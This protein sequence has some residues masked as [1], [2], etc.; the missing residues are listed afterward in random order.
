M[1][2]YVLWLTSFVGLYMAIFWIQI[3]YFAKDEDDAIYDAK[4]VTIIIPAFN[5]ESSI[6]RALKSLADLD[7]PKDKLH[8]I[9]VDDGSTDDTAGK[10]SK[11][12]SENPGIRINLVRH[13][14]NSGNKAVALNTGLQHVTT[15]FFGC[16]DA[17]S[18]AA[19]SSLRLLMQKFTNEN[20][21]AVIST[22]KIRSPVNLIERVQRLD[23]II[24]AFIRK[25]MSRINTLHVTP[26]VLSIYR[27][28]VIRQLG[29][30][31][32]NN[33]TEDLEIAMR[34]QYHRYIIQMQPE[35][36]T[37]TEVP[38]TLK[39]LWSQ[40]VRWYRG[41]IFNSL[42]YREMLF[43][44]KHG[45]MGTFQF[46]MNVLAV[47]IVFAMF[48]IS[49][50]EVLTS[51]YDFIFRI[52]LVRL[53]IFH[54]FNNVSI[55]GAL[56]SI[57][58]KLLFP[59]AIAFLLGIY[60]YNQAHLSIRERWKYPATILVYFTLYPVL[61]SIQWIAAIYYEAIGSKRRW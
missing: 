39:A 24:A 33:I 46:P 57:N 29:C 42:K 15:E 59:I 48:F 44:R 52:F 36:I 8:I 17:D 9:V 47:I 34:L 27:T 14:A 2:E 20:V 13:E 28:E 43:S 37:Y 26:G 41:F 61:R 38:S 54:I 51:L 56:L 18:S 1:I 50:Y 21:A 40:R 58:V 11:F 7:Y 3:I 53:G 16:L 22:T 5:E 55:K 6:T 60:L 25:L 4:Q 30:F 23:Y 49:L 10:A 45:L 12:M 31:D 19:K 32:A 35:S